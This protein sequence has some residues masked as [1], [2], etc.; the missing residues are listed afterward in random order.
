MTLKQKLTNILEDLNSEDKADELWKKYAKIEDM[1]KI[2]VDF[3][4][5]SG[6]IEVQSKNLDINGQP[7]LDWELNTKTGDIV[8]TSRNAT[9]GSERI[10]EKQVDLS[11]LKNPDPVPQAVFD[12]TN[13]NA[14][15]SV[16]AVTPATAT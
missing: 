1:K 6:K 14:V 4:T 7:V 12:V 16:T 10:V 13:S 15:K 3:D 2:S 8:Q 11:T 5:E 9:T